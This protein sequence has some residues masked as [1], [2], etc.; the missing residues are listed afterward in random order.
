MRQRVRV[1]VEVCPARRGGGRDELALVLLDVLGPVTRK[2]DADEKKTKK[3]DGGDGKK[4]EKRDG[5]DKK[6]TKRKGKSVDAIKKKRA[7]KSV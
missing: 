2:R 1:R 4:T 5:G 3:R 7:K 6:K